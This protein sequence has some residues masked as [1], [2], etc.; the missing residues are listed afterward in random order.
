M[1]STLKG[2]GKINTLYDSVI[3]AGGLRK[4][5]AGPGPRRTTLVVKAGSRRSPRIKSGVR[6]G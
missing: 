2:F 5:A 3:P 4:Q 6:P 1:M